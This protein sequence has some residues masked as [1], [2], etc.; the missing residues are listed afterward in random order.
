MRRIRNVSLTVQKQYLRYTLTRARVAREDAEQK[1][2]P[3]IISFPVPMFAHLFRR[4]SIKTK[5]MFSMASCLL[6]FLA[7]SSTLSVTLTAKGLRERA[8]GQE[9]PAV[10]GEIRNDVLRQITGPVTASLGI[11]GNVYLHAWEQ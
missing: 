4:S 2:F 8:V 11:A 10:V 5:L 9:L 3:S 7:I 1:Y 6:L